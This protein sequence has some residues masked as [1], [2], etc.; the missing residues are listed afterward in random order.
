MNADIPDPEEAIVDMIQRLREAADEN[1]QK[2]EG[3]AEEKVWGL[4]LGAALANDAA[5]LFE[6]VL[7]RLSR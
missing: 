2:A 6:A 7:E 1:L 4:C 5:D 3:E